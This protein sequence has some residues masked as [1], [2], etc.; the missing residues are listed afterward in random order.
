MGRIDVTFFGE[1]GKSQNYTFT[2][3]KI[4]GDGESHVF[5]VNSIS[6]HPV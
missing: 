5:P 1:N 4:K 3:N 2:S 6:F